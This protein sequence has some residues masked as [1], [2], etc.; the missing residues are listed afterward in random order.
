MFLRYPWVLQVLTPRMSQIFLSEK[1]TNYTEN[2][3]RCRQGSEFQGLFKTL[4]RNQVLLK[5]T[6][7]IQDLFKIVWTTLKTK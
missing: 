7:K 4:E 6:T 5:M 1:K 3:V 2:C